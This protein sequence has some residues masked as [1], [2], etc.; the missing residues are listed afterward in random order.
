[1][2]EIGS[3]VLPMHPSYLKLFITDMQEVNSLVRAFVV[4]SY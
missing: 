4:I 3:P 2:T 1:M